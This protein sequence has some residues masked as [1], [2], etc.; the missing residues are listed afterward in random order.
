[1][2]LGENMKR[3]SL[4]PLNEEDLTQHASD[5]QTHAAPT[6]EL[7]KPT[8]SIVEPSKDVAPPIKE[9][10][11]LPAATN[12]IESNGEVTIEFKPSLR[13]KVNKITASISGKLTIYNIGFINDNLSARCANYQTVG[14]VLKDIKSIDLTMIQFFHYYTNIK[15]A[16]E[17]HVTFDFEK[18]D[19]TMLKTLDVCNYLSL[20]HKTK[21][22]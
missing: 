6:N 3:K 13:T 9:E 7:T 19:A 16:T 8:T 5:S 18:P 21:Q 17:H 12:N 20:L 11:A 4:I 10:P 2:A 22:L 14:I 15:K 1:M